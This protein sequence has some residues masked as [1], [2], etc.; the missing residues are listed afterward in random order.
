EEQRLDLLAD[1]LEA[2][3]LEKAGVKVARV[4][5]QHVNPA[6]LLDRRL[7]GRLRVF[8]AGD[9]ER[10]GQ[11]I[12][13]PTHCRADLRSASAGGDHG[14]SGGQRCSCD[15]HAQTAAR[16]GDEPNLLLSH[17]QWVRDPNG[18]TVGTATRKKKR[19]RLTTV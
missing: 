17:G 16:A 7:D 9:V 2:E 11:Q 5:D 12:G 4:V 6:E 13:V 15:G 19:P 3:L 10:R 8:G 14:V 18:R 1:P